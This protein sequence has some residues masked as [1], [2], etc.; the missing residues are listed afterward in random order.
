MIDSSACNETRPIYPYLECCDNVGAS[1]YQCYFSY[2]NDGDTILPNDTI[3]NWIIDD[4]ARNFIDLKNYTLYPGYRGLMH[5]VEGGGLDHMR[6]E[7]GNYYTGGGSIC[8]AYEPFPV[9]IEFHSDSDLI[10]E[11]VLYSCIEDTINNSTNTPFDL[12][13]QIEKEGSIFYLTALHSDIEAETFPF[14]GTSILIQNFGRELKSS[15]CYQDTWN[16]TVIS[17]NVTTHDRAEPIPLNCENFRSST[18]ALVVVCYV[19]SGLG[20]IAYVFAKYIELRGE[21]DNKGVIIDRDS[22]LDEVDHGVNI[23]EDFIIKYRYAYEKL[24]GI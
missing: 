7:L 2:I 17:A 16:F 19:I 11:L 12:V 14:N 20:F 18:I 10:D 1:K 24:N 3:V 5:V 22:E 9:R 23:D 15:D 4:V 8:K 6:W 21:N 13:R